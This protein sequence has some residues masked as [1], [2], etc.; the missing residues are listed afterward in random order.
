MLIFPFENKNFFGNNK[1]NVAA[2]NDFSI[3]GK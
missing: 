2:A 3:S 1:I